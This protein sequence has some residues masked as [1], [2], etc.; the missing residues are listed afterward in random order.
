MNMYFSPQMMLLPPPISIQW[1]LYLCLFVVPSLATT[2]FT[3]RIVGYQ[4]TTPFTLRIVGYQA[5]TPFILRIVGYQ[6]TTYFMTSPP[7]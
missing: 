7:G 1:Y 6:A 3:L 4:A 2:P 5:T